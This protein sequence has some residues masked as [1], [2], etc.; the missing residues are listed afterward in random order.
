MWS[1]GLSS[2]VPVHLLW[3]LRWVAMKEGL[4]VSDPGS[5]SS[6]GQAC[7]RHAAGPRAPRGFLSGRVTS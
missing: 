4:R 3:W 5:L 6:Q 2:L 1:V 7:R